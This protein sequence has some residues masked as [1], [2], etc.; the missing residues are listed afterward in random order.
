MRP[1]LGPLCVHLGGL[2]G[3]VAIYEAFGFLAFFAG[4]FAIIVLGF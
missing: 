4:V 1:T 2:L 3:L